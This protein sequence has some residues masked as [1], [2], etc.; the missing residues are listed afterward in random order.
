[1]GRASNFASVT[2]GTSRAFGRA[3]RYCTSVASLDPSATSLRP[4]WTGGDGGPRARRPLP[5]PN[6]ISPKMRRS[7]PGTDLLTGRGGM[8]GRPRRGVRARGGRG[9][10]SAPLLSNAAGLW[11]GPSPREERFLKGAHLA[12][13]VI[14]SYRPSVARFRSLSD[15]SCRSGSDRHRLDRPRALSSLAVFFVWATLVRH[16][17]HWMRPNSRK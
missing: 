16:R 5:H 1:M 10:R 8:C 9:R 2:R 15:C 4:R 14:R 13:L 17:A 3:R 7:R 6:P 11:P 12:F